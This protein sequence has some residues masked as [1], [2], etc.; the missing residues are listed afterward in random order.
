MGLLSH[1]TNM[2]EHKGGLLARAQKIELNK[3][4]DSKEMCSVAKDFYSFVTESGLKNCGIYSP[5][6][7]F[8]YLSNCKGMDLISI[9]NSFSTKDFWNGINLNENEWNSFSNDSL[10]PFFQLF[11]KTKREAVKQIHIL[12]F[13]SKNGLSYFLTWDDLSN[14]C[15]SRENFQST[16]SHNDFSEQKI[17]NLKFESGFE[18]SAAHLFL[19]SAKL[20]MENAFNNL[21]ATAKKTLKNVAMKQLFYIFNKLFASPNCCCLGSDEEI[22]VVMF[23]REEFDEKLLEFQLNNTTAVFFGNTNSTNLLVLNA[24]ICTNQKGTLSFLTQD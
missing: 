5:D 23:S 8:Y 21:S 15:I 17:D 22:K 6:G 12:P 1:I 20:S 18:I 4:N 2:N 14:F 9:Q 7:D 19:V 24:G 11:S 16:L 3:K 13:N 10:T